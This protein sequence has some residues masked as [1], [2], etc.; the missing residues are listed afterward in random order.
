MLGCHQHVA[1]HTELQLVTGIIADPHGLRV[2]I[3]AQ[4]RITLSGDLITIQGIAGA[5]P[6]AVAHDGLRQPGKGRLTIFQR[7]EIDEGFNNQAG[8]AHP[9]VAVI[10]I[11][12]AADPLRQGGGGSS[13]QCAGRGVPEKLQRQG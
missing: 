4:R 2:L 5:Q 9:G 1:I 8:V 12:L 11:F 13:S 3:A 6:D 10:I 7:S